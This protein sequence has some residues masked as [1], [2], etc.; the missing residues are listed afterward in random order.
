MPVRF[1]PNAATNSFSN[2]HFLRPAKLA[3]CLGSQQLRI[4]RVLPLAIPAPYPPHQIAPVVN[5]CYLGLTPK[6]LV[7]RVRLCNLRAG[8][9]T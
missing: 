3:A 8:R 2:F 5:V 6:G 9:I 4:A 7:R 1:R